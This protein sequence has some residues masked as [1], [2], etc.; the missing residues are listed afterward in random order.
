MRSNIEKTILL[1]LDNTI[2][3]ILKE[4]I[5]AAMIE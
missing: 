1:M 4:L 2:T 5:M 3:L